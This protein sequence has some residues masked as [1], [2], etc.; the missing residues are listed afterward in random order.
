MQQRVLESALP[1]AQQLVWWMTRE[2]SLARTQQVLASPLVSV[3]AAFLGRCLTPI[4]HD[5]QATFQ[6][7]VRRRN[8]KV[9][10]SY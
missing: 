1:S 3:L 7:T 2:L 4:G 8:R 10:V 9:S 6:R 5:K